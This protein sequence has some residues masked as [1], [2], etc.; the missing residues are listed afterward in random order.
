MEPT[1]EGKEIRQSPGVRPRPVKGALQSRS[2]SAA[3]GRSAV[4][5]EDE[6]S[7]QMNGTIDP[8]P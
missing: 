3:G 8:A 5:E 2:S 6:L 4:W 1:N 7:A